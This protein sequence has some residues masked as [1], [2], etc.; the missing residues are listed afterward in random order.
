M[1]RRP[2]WGS[3]VVVLYYKL[4]AMSRRHLIPRT[5]SQS[6]TTAW[7]LLVCRG[8]L[9]HVLSTTGSWLL[10]VAVVGAWCATMPLHTNILHSHIHSIS[11]TP[12]RHVLQTLLLVFPVFSAAR[13]RHLQHHVVRDE[14][15]DDEMLMPTACVAG[16]QRLELCTSCLLSLGLLLLY[17][18]WVLLL[19]W[20]LALCVCTRLTRQALHRHVSPVALHY[21]H[22]DVPTNHLP[23]L[24]A[25]VSTPGRDASHTRRAT[26]SFGRR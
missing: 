21:Q 4:D 1:W 7:L 8:C 24:F 9:L 17:G 16:G 19:V 26:R 14:D 13:S 15:D 20:A 5:L 25:C 6:D 2:G 3:S 12:Q 23:C 18:V 10:R 11:M 22:P